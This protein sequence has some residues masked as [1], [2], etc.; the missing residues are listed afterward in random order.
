MS[1][2]LLIILLVFVWALSFA[3]RVPTWAKDLER[4]YKLASPKSN[5]IFYDLWCWDWRIIFEFT[6]NWIRSVWYEISIFFY[7]FCLFKK[8][9]TKNNL[10]EFKFWDFFKKDLSEATIIFIFG[11]DKSINKNKKFREKL[12]KELKT[13]TKI[14][15]YLWEIDWL[16]P[17]KTDKITENDLSIYLYEI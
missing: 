4:I 7:L 13:W 6:K 17:I 11:L 14:I 12:Q 8:I 15:S 5:D 10:A 16:E 2:I 3:P 1:I 9:L